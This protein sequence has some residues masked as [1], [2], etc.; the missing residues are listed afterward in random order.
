MKQPIVYKPISELRTWDRNYRQGDVGAIVNSLNQFGFNGALRLWQDNVVMAGNHTLM[1]LQTMKRQ[2]YD[3]PANVE[4]TAAGEWVVPCVDISHLSEAKARAFAIA[5]NRTAEL[6]ENNDERL[7]ELLQELALDAPDLMEATGYDGDDLDAILAD[8][9]GRSLEDDK[10]TRKVESPHYE[11]S[12]VKPSVADLF[13]D[14]R[15]RDLVAEINAAESLSDDERIF[16]IAAAQRHT[17]LDFGKIA[18]YYAHSGPDIQRLM[19]NSA[20]VIIDYNRAIELGF[21][22]LTEKLSKLRDDEYGDG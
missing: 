14:S 15:T 4:Q 21:V 17:V 22:R 1:A 3:A 10:Y 19:E 6:A 8:L 16:L 18:D 11:P 12:S 2:G 9:E 20:L 7:A 13:D 5:D